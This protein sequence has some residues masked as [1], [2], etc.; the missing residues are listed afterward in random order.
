MCSAK[1]RQ[2][3]RHDLLKMGLR[4]KS[5]TVLADR[6]ITV[7]YSN[8]A[9]EYVDV[10]LTSHTGQCNGRSYPNFDCRVGSL[11]PG[12]GLGLHMSHKDPKEVTH[13]VLEPVPTVHTYNLT[14]T[15]LDFLVVG[16]DGLSGPYEADCTQRITEEEAVRRTKRMRGSPVGKTLEDLFTDWLSD[17][18]DFSGEFDRAQDALSDK[19]DIC[20]DAR[21]QE[22]INKYRAAG[23]DATAKSLYDETIQMYKNTPKPYKDDISIVVML[24]GTRAASS[25]TE[26]KIRAKARPAVSLPPNVTETFVRKDSDKPK[27]VFGYIKSLL[28]KK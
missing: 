17:G 2:R 1:E 14:E 5:K 28:F 4:P 24:N 25:K 3:V 8:A 21:L 9:N 6:R 22:I 7:R 16:S 10:Q 11:Q 20:V 15:P 26:A 13:K 23:V 18:N 27:G 12:R 19:V